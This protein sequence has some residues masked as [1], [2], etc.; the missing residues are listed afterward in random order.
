MSYV[1]TGR[2]SKVSLL[3]L[4][5][6]LILQ[7]LSSIF[8][9]QNFLSPYGLVH[10]V[11]LLGYCFAAGFGFKLSL[12]ASIVFIILYQV[13]SVFLLYSYYVFVIEDP[14][15]INP[16]DAVFYHVMA[17]N[18]S[19]VGFYDSIRLLL[20]THDVGDLGFTQVARLVY[21]LPGEPIINMKLFNIACHVLSSIYLFKVA[22]IIGFSKAGAKVVFVLF[23]LNPASVYFN[24]SG[25][26]EPFFQLLV[27]SSVYQSYRGVIRKKVASSILALVLITATGFFRTTFPLLILLAFLVYLYISAQGARSRMVYRSFI[28]VCLPLLVYLVFG[29]VGDS[30]IYNLNRDYSAVHSYRLGKE[31]VGFIDYV[32]L[33]LSG[34]LGPPPSLSY[35]VSDESSLIKTVPHFIKMIFSVFF[36][37][38]LGS[39]IRE[40]DFRYYP[41]IVIT[42]SN[43]LIFVISAASFD[44]RYFIPTMPML[45][46]IALRSL[47][48]RDYRFGWSFIMM[49]FLSFALTAAYNIRG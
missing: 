38:S 12:N 45:Y 46:L 44:I 11:W 33:F 29:F 10:V 49:C 36:C 15:G 42:V 40:R 22:K 39:I 9:E 2:Y 27:I 24:A 17:I 4:A 5:G 47:S 18:S 21:M 30:L 31:N 1:L 6:F 32:A 28:I 41:L 48:W 25:L 7:C 14:L 26:K 20:A 19:E 16:V 43:I 37:V 34:F 13:I 8:N 3:V 23:A 35:D